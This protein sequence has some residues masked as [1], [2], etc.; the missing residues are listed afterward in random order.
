MIA[1][2]KDANETMMPGG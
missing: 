2:N 1:A